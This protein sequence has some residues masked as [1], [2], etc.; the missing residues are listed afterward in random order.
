MEHCNA[1]VLRSGKQFEG[2]KGAKVEKEGKN[3][4]NE[5]VI[6]LFSEDESLKR[7]ESEKFEESKSH[8][9]KPYMSHF[10]FPQRLLR[11]NLMLNLACFL[12]CLRSCMLMFL[13]L[14]LCHKCQCLLNS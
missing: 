12:M 9:L 4:H 6:T 14:M 11:L 2:L 3:D 7:K 1:I 8:S 10:P 5:G 13:S